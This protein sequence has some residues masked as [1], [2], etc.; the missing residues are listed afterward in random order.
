MARLAGSM[1]P[2]TVL[3]YMREQCTDLSV[4]INTLDLDKT[5][6]ELVI[7]ALEPLP[8]DR[9]CFRMIGNVVV[10][11]TV[12]EVL[13]AVKKNRD[14]VRPRHGPA[15]CASKSLAVQ[16]LTSYITWPWLHLWR[17]KGCTRPRQW[18][19]ASRGP[20]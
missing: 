15:P 19:A 5:E 10:E 17:A 1:D 18:Q 8:G 2:Q 6:H 20:L 14:S 3:N 16:C 7:N 12:A 11:R 9:K 4:K 13:P